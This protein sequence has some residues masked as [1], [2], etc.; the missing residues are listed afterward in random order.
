MESDA[1]A[2]AKARA[3]AWMLEK[4]PD[5]VNH[6]EELEKIRQLIDVDE[7]HITDGEGILIS[8]TVKEYYLYRFDADK[9]SAAF[10][11]RFM[12]KRLN[13]LRILSPKA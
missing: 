2:L 6:Y 9:Q 5:L 11:P 8:G 12:I 13:W 7:L 4:D 3:F 1:N 10:L